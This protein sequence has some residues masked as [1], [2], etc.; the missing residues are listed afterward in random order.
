MEVARAYKLQVNGGETVEEI[1]AR[2]GYSDSTV[3]NYLRLLE[4]EPKHQKKVEA[5]NMTLTAALRLLRN[6]QDEKAAANCVP[7]KVK[8]KKKIAERLT[9]LQGEVSEAAMTPAD[10]REA[11]VLKWVL[12]QV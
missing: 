2:E 8:S 12:G 10:Q 5:G 1:A 3:N 9:A 7:A 4:L 11:E 6:G